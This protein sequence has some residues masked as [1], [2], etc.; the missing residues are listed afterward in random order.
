[1]KKVIFNLKSTSLLLLF[2]SALCLNNA[3]AF[4]IKLIKSADEKKIVLDVSSLYGETATCKI[5]DH[6]GIVIFS[7]N[8]KKSSQ[9]NKKY[10]LNKLVS[11]T[12]KLI[13]EDAMSVE[14]I[15]FELNE[16]SIEYSEKT[17]TYYKPTVTIKKNN[18]VYV[19]MLSLSKHVTMSIY[20]DN[21]VLHKEEIENLDTI[22]KVVDFSAAAKGTYTIEVAIGDQIFYNY[23]KI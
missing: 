12:Y 5:V 16:T 20:K 3:N 18:L 14:T 2:L 7:D 23:I 17:T 22:S 19:N 1:M 11:G 13:L 8:I 21:D 6:F 9:I 15:N 4:S 10:D